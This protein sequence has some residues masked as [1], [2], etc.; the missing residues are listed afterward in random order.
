MQNQHD[1]CN[2]MI[3]NADGNVK[4]YTNANKIKQDVLLK[5]KKKL[6]MASISKKYNLWLR[7]SIPGEYFSE[8]SESNKTKSNALS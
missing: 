7:P 8:Q 1:V 6:F 5:Q 4:H 2:F 3:L